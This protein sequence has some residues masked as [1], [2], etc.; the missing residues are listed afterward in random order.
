MLKYIISFLVLVF[1]LAF[2][3]KGCGTSQNYSIK[4]E[5]INHV[6][7]TIKSVISDN[8]DDTIKS[9][10]SDN[11][12]SL[13]L[14]TLQT[15]QVDT[16]HEVLKDEDY[17]IT[18]SIVHLTYPYRSEIPRFLVTKE[19]QILIRRGYICSYNQDTRNANWV[20]WHL[21]KEHTDGPWSRKGIPYIE[22]SSVV[23][24][25]PDNSDWESVNLKQLGIDHG[26]LCPAGDNKWDKE[27]MIQSFLLTNMCPQNSMLNQGIWEDLESRCRGWAR[28]FGDIYI[29]A[30]PIFYSNDY[31]TIGA[32]KI[33]IPDAFFKVVL[34]LS[35]EP[36][37]IGFIFPNSD[38]T[39]TKIGDYML[40]VDQVEEITQID[41]FHNLEDNIENTIEANSNLNKW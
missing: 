16:F 5:S 3:I 6:D 4:T 38:P 30:G 14:E 36:K 8:A 39:Y 7:D 24:I 29:V 17:F 13:Y 23:G 18:D 21:T 27:A 40:S 22:D 33:G 37:A 2:M 31:K 1:S 10:I 41:F 11:L 20:A 25:S 35:K 26:H 34:C 28:N 19:E 15:E 32:N 12:D 9:L